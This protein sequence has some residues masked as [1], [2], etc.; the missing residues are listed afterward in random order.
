MEPIADS[1]RDT[2]GKTSALEENIY[3]LEGRLEAKDQEIDDLAQIASV[4]TSM[5][6]IES[7]LAVTMETSLRRVAGEV[8]AILLAEGSDLKVKIA[9]GVDA[10]DLE[11]LTYQDGRSLARYCFETQE[12]VMEGHSQRVESG[13]YSIHSLIAAPILTQSRALGVIVIFNKGDD[14]EFDSQDR[15]SLEMIGSFAAVAIENSRLLRESVDR[16]KMEQELE[17]ACQVQT[18]L[19]PESFGVRG[20]QVASTYLPAGH[21]G[22]DYYDIIPL[23]DRRVLFLLG[24]VTN[25]GV[26]AA[27]VM[28]AAYSI[29]HGYVG[30]RRE[31]DIQDLMSHL[32]EVL[33]RHIIKSRDMFITLFAAFVDIDAGTMEYSN[34]G[35]PPAFFSR[36]GSGEVVRLKEGGPPLGQF[37]GQTYRSVVLPVAGGDRVFCYS[38]GLIEAENGRGERYGLARLEEFFI[39][40]KTAAADGFN[41]AVKEEI[42]RFGVDAGRETRDD[43][44]TLVFDVLKNDSGGERYQ[45]VYPSRLDVLD[46][47]YGDMER[48]FG[49]HHIGPKIAH[50]FRLAV[51]EAFTN[52]IIHAHGQDPGKLIDVSIAVNDGR[53]SADI[54]DEGSCW[55]NGGMKQFDPARDPAAE[56]G[57]GL[58]LIQRLS[59]EVSFARS[60]RG[61]T[62]VTITKKLT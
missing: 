17:L 21:V 58:G 27:L 5:L 41:Q 59:D 25:K 30:S 31:I 43:F 28:T 55:K 12:A 1:R 23:T 37:A 51:S 49:R 39:S 47:F 29:I 7:V 24:D 14:G 53:L 54:T 2:L 60:S 62:T 35:H 26:P 57:R 61:G 3:D 16:Q 45:F 32:N 20:L 8:G 38:D 33:C 11:K 50:P 56:S 18:T 46:T 19:L 34:G 10:D 13:G 40:G 15:R 36:A 6:D 44:T 4:I 48:V 22:G 9:W 42:A 52:A